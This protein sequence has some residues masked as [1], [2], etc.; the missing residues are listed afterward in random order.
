MAQ[1]SFPAEPHETD[2]RTPAPPLL[3]A[4]VFENSTTEHHAQRL[5]GRILRMAGGDLPVQECA[6]GF[7]V[8]DQPD[9][10][11]AAARRAREAD[12]V[13]VAAHAH[14]AALGRV[15]EWLEHWLGPRREKH[16]ALVYIA[17]EREV[18]GHIRDSMEEQLAS[19]AR[20][21]GMD[22]FATR[23]APGAELLRGEH[24]SPTHERHLFT[25]PF[26]GS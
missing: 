8:F 2:E 1:M 11:A 24:L 26:L 21:I 22:F 12:V 23:I 19:V 16:G 3:V 18:E 15:L 20:Q 9:G 13:V 17:V 4:T 5:I 6:L 10:M 25:R 14:C 7:Q